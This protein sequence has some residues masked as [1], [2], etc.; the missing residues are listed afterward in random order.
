M[1]KRPVIK[2]EVT[3][4]KRGVQDT[5]RIGGEVRK[6]EVRV[7]REGDVSVHESGTGEKK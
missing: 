6:E 3:V 2:E 1:K 5:E 7:V 4:G